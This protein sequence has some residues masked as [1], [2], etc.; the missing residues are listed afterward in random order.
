[1]NQNQGYM[2]ITVFDQTIKDHFFDT[3]EEAQEL[4]HDELV[5]LGNVPFEIIQQKRFDNGTYG[6]I[7]DEAYSKMGVGNQT[8]L[9]R[10]ISLSGK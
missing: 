9:W 8:V 7:E 3:L 2:L 10:I 5:A 6:F 1:M 4:M